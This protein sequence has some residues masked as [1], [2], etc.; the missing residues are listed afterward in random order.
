MPLHARRHHDGMRAANLAHHKARRQQWS[1]RKEMP[2]PRKWGGNRA[3]A[4]PTRPESFSDSPGGRARIS[5]SQQSDSQTLGSSVTVSGVPRMPSELPPLRIG[6]PHPSPREFVSRKEIPELLT[7]RNTPRQAVDL[8]TMQAHP[9]GGGA[10]AAIAPRRKQTHSSNNT[11]CTERRNRPSTSYFFAPAGTL[12]SWVL[13]SFGRS[14]VVWYSAKSALAGCISSNETPSYPVMR[15]RCGPPI[16]PRPSLRV[17]Y[18]PSR[19]SANPCGPELPFDE[20]GS[21]TICPAGIGC[22]A[23]CAV[24]D[25]S[26]RCGPD[27]PPQPVSKPIVPNT[28]ATPPSHIPHAP[29]PQP[30]ALIRY[31]FQ[32]NN[33]P[34]RIHNRLRFVPITTGRRLVDVH[35]DRLLHE[36]HRTVG[37]GKLA[38]ARMLAAETH[39]VEIRGQNRSDDRKS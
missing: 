28:A 17:S 6:T 11:F 39:V 35:V 19:I 21:N 34:S 12:K 15:T 1:M 25:S 10:C 5:H 22:P 24:P 32:E 26:Y 16:V 8:S 37:H 2:P 27:G 30:E 4:C 13:S 23:N 29:P 18:F 33:K 31:P 38:S 3:P 14:T 20:S 7:K 9:Q 36:R